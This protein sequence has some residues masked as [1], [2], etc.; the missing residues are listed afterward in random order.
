MGPYRGV[1]SYVAVLVLENATGVDSGK[2]VDLSRGISRGSL[3]GQQVTDVE[4]SSEGRKLVVFPVLWQ[5][6]LL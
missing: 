4:L 6:L 2:A 3:Q 1:I 5:D